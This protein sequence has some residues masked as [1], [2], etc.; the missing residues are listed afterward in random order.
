MGHIEGPMLCIDKNVRELYKIL[1]S[2]QLLAAWL[3][4][5][6]D[7]FT[8][9]RRLD[10]GPKPLRSDGCLAGLPDL[11]PTDQLRVEQGNRR[12]AISVLVI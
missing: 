10:G 5:P 12:L 8:T 1:Q 9:A 11:N 6:C 4:T 3:G 2:P 7:T